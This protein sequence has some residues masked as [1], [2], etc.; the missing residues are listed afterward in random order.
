M[1]KCLLSI[2]LFSVVAVAQVYSPSVLRKGQIDATDL[3]SL[4][5]S[6]YKAAGAV[7]ERQKA[8]AIWR[9]FLTDGRFVTPGFWYH[10]AGWTYEEPRGEVLDPIKLLN[11]YG[12]GL[13]YHIA[14]LLEAVFEAGGFRDARVWFLT[15]HTVTEVFYGGAYHYFDS[16]MMGYNTIG[17][18]NV[19]ELPVASVRQIEEDGSIIL[20]KLLSPKEVDPALVDY[21]WYPADLREAAIG[22]L[23]ELFTTTSDNWLYPYKRYS[24]GHTMDFVLRRGES[25]I[26]Y[27]EPEGGNLYYLPYKLV[28]G[29]WEEFPQEIRSYN[30]RTENG[31]R[32]QK[33]ARKWATG[34]IE[35]TPMLSDPLAYYPAL[36]QNLK[37]PKPGEDE[38][39]LR[40]KDSDAPA[41]VVFD[42]ASPYVIINANIHMDAHLK[43]ERHNLVIETSIDDGKT[44][45]GAATLHGPFDGPWSTSVGTR[46]RSEHG[47]LTA[48]SGTYGY[49]LRI[50][51][52]GPGPDD[53]LRVSRIKIIT[54]FQVNPRTLP[55]LETGRNQMLYRP[56]AGMRRHAIPV[57][58]DKVQAYAY[59]AANFRY[60]DENSQGFLMPVEGRT[61][62]LVL[63]LASPDRSPLEG[64]DAG[65]HFLDI[66]DG[67]APDKLTAEVRKTSIRS[68]SG[69]SI[70][71]ASLSWATSPEGPYT[72]LW[73]Y[74]EPNWLDGE[75]I[76]RTL[77]WPEVDRR[78]KSLPRGTRKVY[79]RYRLQGMA[80]DD[81]RLATLSPG[82]SSGRLEIV[83]LWNE[84]GHP[85]RHV[86]QIA[87]PGA[88]HS[89]VVSA[90]EIGKISNAAVI[91]SCH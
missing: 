52:A 49:L 88:A 82:I 12:F 35:Y 9:F 23:A 44:W 19:H 32:S 29:R 47:T 14:P 74:E 11:S 16:D 26:R 57:R 4:A 87:N 33:D 43:T 36:N 80:L 2:L 6:I 50:R 71:A 10:I 13:C 79:I 77:R 40:R 56:R 59:K 55:A 70:P 51:M 84:N 27:F 34:L 54:R 85:K 91:L 83:H 5:Q 42:V 46:L 39:T 65:G 28:G 61:A 7:T 22:G 53:A 3:A 24:Q 67:L 90:G 21:P 1:R 66:R 81:I 37:L 68:T 78:V 17:K 63:E 75:V 31:P 41:S 86:E 20:G 73:H 38:R 18:G 62:E 69:S 15:G 48:V 58:V 64:F 45:D 25:L 76:H 8:E 89:Y 72:E 60:V 30:I